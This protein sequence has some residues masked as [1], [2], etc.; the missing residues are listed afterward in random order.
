[1][2]DN[3]VVPL[4]GSEVAEAA[5]PYAEELSHKL[6]SNVTLL[7]LIRPDHRQYEGMHKVYLDSVANRFGVSTTESKRRPA[8]T[9]ETMDR[10]VQDSVCEFAARNAASLI[11]MTSVGASGES[12][13]KLLGS[14]ADGVCRST[15]IPVLLVK[16]EGA[17]QRKDGPLIRRIMV[18]LDGSELSKQALPVAEELA[19]QLAAP[20]VL[21]QMARVVR[22]Y[23][24]DPAPFVDYGRLTEDEESRVRQEMSAVAERL[25]GKGFEV[26]YS[27]VSGTDAAG[28][29]LDAIQQFGVDLVVMSTHGRGGLGRV[30]FGSVAEKVLKQARVPLLL[31][32]A[33]SD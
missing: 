27:V 12:A 1:M 14:V 11:V 32:R 20:L 23:G 5:L 7:H 26:T 28:E 18:T 33:R 6:G 3:V 22:S 15:P 29:I 13:G 25:C 24:G 17:R 9:V 21:F 10:P 2:F 31:V 30:V 8:V 19:R 4:D 16:P